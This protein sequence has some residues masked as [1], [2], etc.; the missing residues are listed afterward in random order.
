MSLHPYSPRFGKKQVNIPQMALWMCQ[1]GQSQGTTLFLGCHCLLFFPFD[2]ESGI[3][4]SLLPCTGITSMLSFKNKTKHYH[5][6]QHYHEHY[7][8]NSDPPACLWDKHFTEWATSLT[9]EY[10]YFCHFP[11]MIGWVPES[12]TEVYLSAG[13]RFRALCLGRI[14]GEH[15]F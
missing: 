15:E 3:F 2:T 5:H 11:R 7:R 12:V 8:P 10:F 1:V 6:H 14:H 9:L 13:S 4:L